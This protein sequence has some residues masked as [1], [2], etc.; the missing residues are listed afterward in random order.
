MFLGNYENKIDKKCRVSI[1]ATFRSALA[2]EPFSGVVGFCSFRYACIEFTGMSFMETLKN[3]ASSFDLFSQEHDDLTMAIFGA[4]QPLVMDGD[5]RITL[6][7]VFLDYTRITEQASFI[8]VGDF[9]QLWEPGSLQSHL[10]SARDRA[11]QRGLT[12]PRLD[13][14]QSEVKG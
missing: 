9:F 7:K 14:K 2:S 4:A 1:P 13:T 12:L 6:P 10:A 3:R 8:G 11:K 5:G